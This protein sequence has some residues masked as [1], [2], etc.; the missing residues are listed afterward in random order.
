VKINVSLFSSN[1]I[2]F[3]VL[4]F[5]TF[6]GFVCSES[7]FHSYKN[8]PISMRYMQGKISIL[9]VEIVSFHIFYSS[10]PNK[11]EFDYL[12]KSNIK[13]NSIKSY[14]CPIG[15]G[16]FI[17]VWLNKKNANKLHFTK[18]SYFHEQKQQMIIQKDKKSK[19][20]KGKNFQS[21]KTFWINEIIP[22]P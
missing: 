9:Y 21:S 1:L 7:S 19:K 18:S 5:I 11:F 3:F 4:Q 8:M 14:S 2:D 6:T 20:S 10:K 17:L 13:V 15:N 12:K 16:K 22:E